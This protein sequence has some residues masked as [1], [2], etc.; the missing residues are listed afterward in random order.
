[1]KQLTII[2]CTYNRAA[3]LEECLHSLAG[4]NAD[5]SLFEV[6]IVDNNSTDSTKL[7]SEKYCTA[8]S[9]FSYCAETTTGL[10]Q[11]RNTGYKNAN[12]P[13]V[14]YLD[15]D[16]K[17]A[18]SFAERILYGIAHFDFDAYGGI[19]LPWYKFGKKRWM[20]EER[21][22]TNKVNMPLAPGLLK[23]KNYFSGGNC[24]F[25]KTALEGI[26]GF[27]T[28]IGMKGAQVSYGEETLTQ[29]QLRKAGKKVG[30]DP[31]LII[32]HVVMPYK[33]N[34]KWF[35]RSMYRNG[36]DHW[37][38]FD[39]I[40]TR[41]DL[42]SLFYHGTKNF[43]RNFFI[44]LPKTF[45]KDY[46]FQNWMIDVFCEYARVWGVVKGGRKKLRSA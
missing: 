16:A 30:W 2:V 9:N 1:M 35:F 7:I 43:I 11:A 3:L 26:G 5:A 34:L 23:E 37:N 45:R 33:L 13:W 24:V 41:K 36:V 17:A 32:Y 31:E 19:Y 18:E 22:F 10:S 21:F 40:P 25:R 44:H 39:E 27:N 12:T 4:Q 28:E 42:R 14:A 15:D 46:Y 38:T 29:V 20:D 6:L 8:R